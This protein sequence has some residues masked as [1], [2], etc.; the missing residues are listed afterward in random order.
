MQF[1]PISKSAET[2]SSL[3][4]SLAILSR[5]L[6]FFNFSV[7][8]ISAESIGICSLEC[9]FGIFTHWILLSLDNSYFETISPSINNDFT[10]LSPFSFFMLIEVLK[11]DK[12]VS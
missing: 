1:S 10:F 9:S 4:M 6:H 12:Q 8:A 11:P 5:Y 2:L 3:A 7:V